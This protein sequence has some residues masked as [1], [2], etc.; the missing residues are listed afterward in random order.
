MNKPEQMPLFDRLKQI[1]TNSIKLNHRKK[2]Q[3]KTLS[4]SYQDM[5]TQMRGIYHH[6]KT[7]LDE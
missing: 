1:Q 6:T 3:T 2:P 4:N 5:D 7:C